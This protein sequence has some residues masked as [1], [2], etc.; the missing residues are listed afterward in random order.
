MYSRG[1]RQKV[2]QLSKDNEWRGKHNMWIGGYDDT[3]GDYSEMLARSI[4]CLV[5]PGAL[6]GGLVLLLPYRQAGCS[7]GGE[8]TAERLPGGKPV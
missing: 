8:G 2:Y 5:M 1:I 3:P 6:P 7:A 4:F